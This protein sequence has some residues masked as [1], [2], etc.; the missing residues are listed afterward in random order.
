MKTFDNIS[1]SDKIRWR[2]RGLWCLFIAMLIYM[3]VIGELKLGDS[4]MMT[5]LAELVSRIIFFGGMILVLRRIRYYN[6]LLIN[7]WN[8]KEKMLQEKDERN[9]FLHEKSGGIAWDILF[10]IQLFLTL[11]ASLMDMTAFSYMMISLTVM[12]LLKLILYMYAA[13]L[14]GGGNE[15]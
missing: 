8:L 11:T 6:R 12:I 2:I 10:F 13:H 9:R 5:R 4:R 3:V 1:F 7:K 14:S 15:T